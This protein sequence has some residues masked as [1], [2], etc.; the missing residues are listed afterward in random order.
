MDLAD[1]F[2]LLGAGASARAGVPLAFGFVDAIREHLDGLESPTREALLAEFEAI[3]TTLESHSRGRV[4]LEP[5]FEAIDDRLEAHALG[6]ASPNP[7]RASRALERIH[8][9]TRRVIQNKC[10]VRDKR[11]CGYWVPLLSLLHR[12]AKPYPIVT[13]NYDNVVENACDLAGFT[14]GEEVLEKESPTAQKG[15]FELVKVHGSVT[16][17]PAEKAGTLKRSPGHGT[18]IMTQYG[19]LRSATIETPLIYPSRRKMPLQKPFMRNALRL[20]ELLQKKGT[21]IVIGYS[22]PDLHVRTWIADALKA[23]TKLRIYLIAPIAGNTALDN[24]VRRM[25]TEPWTQRLF[26]L[27]QKLEDIA[28]DF[29]KWIATAVRFGP[30]YL[31]ADGIS[32][33]STHRIPVI[34]RISGLGAAPDGKSLL[35]A[36]GDGASRLLR[37]DLDTEE[38]HVLASGLR[39]PRGIACTNDGRVLVVQNSFT[40]IPRVPSIG[41]GTIIEIAPDGRKRNL[42]K[43]RFAEVKDVIAKLVRG[44]S[45]SQLRKSVRF[46]LNWPT[47]VA[48][49]E[50]DG[51]IFAT[52]A[53]ALVRVRRNAVPERLSERALMFNLH[54]LDV[55][56]D[57]AIVGVE[58]GIGQAFS[59]GRVERFSLES[60]GLH[61]TDC[62]VLEGRT[63]LMALCYA[64]PT[65]SIVI[66]QTLAWPLGALVF[67]NYPEMDD[68]RILRGFDMPQKIE[69]VPVREQL[70]VSTPDGLLLLSL[71]AA[72][73]A[74]VQMDD[75]SGLSFRLL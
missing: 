13:F 33:P 21:C 42:T 16:W 63:R 4:G 6:D 14:Y 30:E 75:I 2:F 18:A 54:G 35:L 39:N 70:A 45:W 44:E 10:D 56:D 58:Q 69:F 41:A 74:A 55:A 52:E 72:F 60:D 66:T 57:G 68:V 7:L 31:E 19:E 17:L 1:S 46:L 22:F 50:S 48:W 61:V 29:E 47:D 32:R 40:D 65:R 49:R 26:V 62:A 64:P 3:R 34:G 9:E 43:L 38:L 27:G 73:D 51:A 23:N 53:R 36:E 11:I 59:W 67:V 20:Q 8:Y 15:D 71:E 5:F 37:L 25:P 28:D 24:L 12:F